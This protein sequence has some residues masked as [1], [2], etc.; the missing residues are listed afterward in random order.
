MGTIT[1]RKRRDGSIGYTVQIRKKRNG[2]V[3]YTESETFERHAA[4]VAWERKREAELDEPGALEKAIAPPAD[5][6]LSEAIDA[7]LTDAQRGGKTKRQ[8]LRTIKTLEIAA[9]QCSKIDSRHI[10]DLAKY[11]L[12]TG[13]LPQTVGNYI[14][15]LSTIFTIARPAWG[16]PLSKEAMDDAKIVIKKLN[17][18]SR[19]VS[20]ERLPTLQELND[21]LD[22]FI[23]NRA[24]RSNS[25]PMAH[26]MVYAIY[27]TRRLEE[28]TRI[29]FE[30]IKHPTQEDPQGLAKQLVRDMKHPGEK[31]GNDVWVTLTPEAYVMTMARQKYQGET[32]RIF[33]YNPSSISSRFTLAC[34]LLGIE[35]LHFHDLRHQGITRLFEL[36]WNIPNVAKV[37]G[38]RSWNS[39]RRYTHLE[40]VGDKLENW[41][42][43][44]KL[45]IQA[46]PPDKQQQAA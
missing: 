16:F 22:Y 4:A 1:P 14:S 29:T 27:S 37:S 42:W 28:I 17:L 18:A 2:K 43:V 45:G 24:E 44:E 25:V 10:V 35:D 13:M 9:L 8:V 26:I 21:L 20:R 41:P 23:V 36:G 30:D 5:P 39:L 40:K 31:I 34:K 19:S 38:H 7:Y 33:P 6:T 3:V 32:G 11:L 46:T 12:N 15:H